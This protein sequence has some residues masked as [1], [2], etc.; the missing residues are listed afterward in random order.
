MNCLSKLAP[1]PFRLISIALAAGSLVAACGGDEGVT[2]VCPN[3]EDCKTQPGP[4][5]SKDDAGDGAET[6][7]EDEGDESTE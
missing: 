1:M 3:A 2:P 5:P 4:P 7:S 6:G